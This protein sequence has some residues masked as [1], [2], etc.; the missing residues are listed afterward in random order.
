M[1]STTK[2]RIAIFI[3]LCTASQAHAGPCLKAIDRT[4]AQLDV[5]IEKNAGS[6]GWKRE[7]LS[8]LRSY[9]PTPR[10]LAEAEAGN[11][12]DFTG[13][14]DALD[15]ARAAD[16]IGDIAACDRELAQA[17]AVLR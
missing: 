3:L 6:H 17:R 9:Q 2:G 12:P 7:S 16:Q 1:T 11:G 15:R 4:Q 8:A 5:A 14:L 13:A 10:S